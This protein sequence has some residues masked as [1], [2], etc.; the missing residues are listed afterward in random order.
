[1]C[2]DPDKP[3]AIISKARF[4]DL[5]RKE[6]ALR[7]AA[8]SY[9]STSCDEP[10]CD[11]FTLE[12]NRD[13]KLNLQFLCEEIFTCE[14]QMENYCDAHKSS[15]LIL[16]DEQYRCEYCIPPDIGEDISEE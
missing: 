12:S 5:E 2:S 13:N 1:V 15:H 7:I 4:A 3:L 14:C 10:G 8:K 9:L 16:I 11:A 6:A